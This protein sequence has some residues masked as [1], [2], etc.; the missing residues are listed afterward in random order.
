M[1]NKM[2]HLCLVL[3]LV[4]SLL[5]ITSCQSGTTTAT[6]IKIGVIRSFTG[7]T[8]AIG[9]ELSRAI[10][11]VLK[12]NNYKVSGRSIEVI[13]A[14]EGDTPEQAIAS[15]KKLVEQDKVNVVMGPLLSNSVVAVSEY[16]KTKGVPLLAFG[17]SDTK[18][19]DYTFF[20]Y[21]TGRG[22]AY[23]AGQ[24]AYDVFGARK[25][26]FLYTDY[27]FSYQLKDGFTDGFTEK[28]GTVVQAIPV[29]WTE[30]DMA[31]YLSQL[32]ETDLL[33]VFVVSTAATF[34]QQYRQFGIK[35]PVF[36]M[37]ALMYE[38]PLLQQLGDDAL[39]MYGSTFYSAE[40]DTPE[41]KAFVASFKETYNYYPT[42]GTIQAYW[43]TLRYINA[44]KA[45]GGDPDPTKVTQ[46]LLSAG[47]IN[48]PAGP[49]KIT[50][51]RTPIQNFY[52]MKVVKTDRY[53]WEVLKTYTDVQPR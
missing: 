44:L 32:K 23:P 47:T 34:V 25:V 28:G 6:V 15:A 20:S 21:G 3:F 9:V 18:V 14:D 10:N 16:L 49:L 19:S 7:S 33:V 38:E 2:L 1:R 43:P 26:T 27:L 4:V 24:W 36:F 31:P 17:P 13:E 52:V 48:T 29:P 11:L 40:I 45:T 30:T 46:A 50:P 5:A 42:F 8:T 53:C 51:D 35:T 22:G 39:D 12:E 37:S 41:N